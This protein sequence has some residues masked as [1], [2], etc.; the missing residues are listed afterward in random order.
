VQNG[1]FGAKTSYDFNVDRYSSNQNFYDTL[2]RLTR[3]MFGINNGARIQDIADGTSNTVA[4]SE[5]TLD[6]RDGITGTWGYSKWVGNG[7]D[8]GV[9][10]INRWPCCAWAL[11]LT[12]VPNRLGTWGAAGSTHTGGAHVL[13]GDGAVR[14]VSENLDINTQ[15]NL[16]R[17]ADGNPV[18]E[19]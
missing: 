17:I 3:R 4:V 1:L 13:L 5:T 12:S 6:I 19:F 18:G 9:N 14:F 11:P 15:L 8:F 7:I 16:A 10:G 2:N